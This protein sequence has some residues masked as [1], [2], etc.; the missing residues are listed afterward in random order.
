VKL[1]IISILYLQL[2]YYNIIF[3]VWW[4]QLFI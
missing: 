2:H 4:L 1:S 3:T